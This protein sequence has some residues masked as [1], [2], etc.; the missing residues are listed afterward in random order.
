MPLS[1]SVMVL[2]RY[3]MPHT[4][5]PSA[6]V[7]IRKPIPE[8]RNASRPNSAPQ[9]VEKTIANNAENSWPKPALSSSTAA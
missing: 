5:C 6:S 3:A 4:I 7:I 8:A 2:A 9:A 1:P